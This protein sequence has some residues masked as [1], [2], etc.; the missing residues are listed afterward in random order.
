[1]DITQAQQDIMSWIENFVETPQAQLSGW[2]P[3]PF[4]RRARLGGLLD[5]RPGTDPYLDGMA[6]EGMAHYDVI[7][8]VYEPMAIDADT[9]ERYINSV[10]PGFLLPRG[11]IALGDH[12][13]LPEVINGVTMNQGQWAIMFVQDL[14]KLNSHARQLADKG[15]YQGWPEAYLQ[16]LFQNRTDPRS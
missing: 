16:S 7:A 10:N 15:F 12:P 9:F 14:A 4:A 13:D 2:P 11:L 8:Y 1:M 3:C 5:I 6:L